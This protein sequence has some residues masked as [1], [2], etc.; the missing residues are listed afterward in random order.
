M[1][2]YFGE[3]RQYRFRW[4]LTPKAP[5]ALLSLGR[6]ASCTAAGDQAGGWPFRGR[7]CG[8]EVFE[9]PL[10]RRFGD[11]TNHILTIFKQI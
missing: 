11:H 9:R 7:N 4:I 3:N 6:Q 8:Y 5:G 10:D 1:E 2:I